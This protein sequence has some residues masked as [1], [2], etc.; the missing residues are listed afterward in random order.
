MLTIKKHI[1]D[2]LFEKYSALAPSPTLTADDLAGFLEY[3]PD[4]KLGDLA[5]PCFKLSKELRKA[6][7]AI[8]A[9]LSEGLDDDIIGSAST[10]GGYLNIKINPAYYAS[11]IPEIIAKGERYGS[12]DFGSG[13]TVVLDYSSPNVAKPFHI[14]HLGTTV[15]GHSLKML[16]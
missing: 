10:A 14:G 3:P 15:I 11:L 2:K 4:D 16:H 13:K 9:A 6:P 5:F 12:F 7:P 1:A 8:A